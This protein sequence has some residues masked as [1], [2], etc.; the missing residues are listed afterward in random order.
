MILV[1]GGAFSIGWALVQPKVAEHTRVC[2]YDRV[3]LAGVIQAPRMKPSSRLSPIFIRSSR[4]LA[5]PLPTCSSVLRFGESTYSPFNTRSRLEYRG[6]IFSNSSD[7]VG[8]LVGSKPF[9]IWSLTEGVIRST[10]P[11]PA[12]DKAV[13]QP[14]RVSPSTGFRRPVGP[15]AYG[16]VCACGKSG[17]QPKQHPNQLCPSERNFYGSS[18]RPTMINI[19]SASFRGGGVVQPDLGRS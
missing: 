7:R 4:P 9:L 18:M 15:F 6:L 1:A 13:R 16:W 3:G 17:T 5:K 19:R 12:S 8:R 11:L 2:S 14:V 10:F